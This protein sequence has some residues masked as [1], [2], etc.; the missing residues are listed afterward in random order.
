MLQPAFNWTKSSVCDHLSPSS[1][2]TFLYSALG[3]WG[4][5]SVN[6]FLLCQLLPVRLCQDRALEGD[7]KKGGE[8]RDLVL[9]LSV[10]VSI[11]PATFP[12]YFLLL[13]GLFPV[14]VSITSASLLPPSSGNTSQQ[15]ELDP[16]CSFA[17]I[18]QQASLWL[19]SQRC[20]HPSSEVWV[21]AP[22]PHF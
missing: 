6:P 4:W 12:V 9:L 19:D 15:Q 11:I 13:I 1:K 22:S 5:D 3:Y 18:C 14:L 10:S 17:N 7:H 21:L 2:P 8:R 16:V 20:W